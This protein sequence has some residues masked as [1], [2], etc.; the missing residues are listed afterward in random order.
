ME[1]EGRARRIEGWENPGGHVQKQK[2]KKHSRDTSPL[3]REEACRCLQERKTLTGEK[4]R[5]KKGKSFKDISKKK[6][7]GEKIKRGGGKK[8]DL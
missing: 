6:L 3:R 1:K 5:R 7:P 8:K 2:V 4:E